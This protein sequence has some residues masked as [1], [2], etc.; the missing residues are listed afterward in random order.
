MPFTKNHKVN[1]GRKFSEERNRK[2]SIAKTGISNEKIKL[3]LTGKKFGRLEVKGYSHTENHNTFWKCICECGESVIKEGSSLK[4]GNTKSCG[5][6]NR[7][8]L[9]KSNYK[10]G[11]RDDPFYKLWCGIRQR[12][13]NKNTVG[14]KN[15]GGR[16]IKMCASWLDFSKFKTD[17]YET[18]LAHIKKFGRR[19]TCIDR[20]D[21]N[22]WY[23][24]KNCKWSTRIEQ[25][26]NTRRNVFIE[27]RGKRLT[28]SGWSRE[29]GVD[30]STILYR[31][32]K[33]KWPLERALKKI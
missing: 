8:S 33:A 32:F 10:H 25:N 18:Y 27:F 31:V 21:N 13:F 1:V 16:G 7:E 11:M 4:C 2:I 15:W 5:C 3:K 23:S 12:C 30:R 14:Y 20:V 24:K 28:M 17:M 6:L 26:S 9:I 19:N 22:K 29:L